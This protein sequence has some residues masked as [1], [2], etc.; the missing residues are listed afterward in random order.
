V[1]MESLEIKIN[2]SD[3]QNRVGS[4]VSDPSFSALSQRAKAMRARRRSHGESA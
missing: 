2:R 1:S 4:I 3:L